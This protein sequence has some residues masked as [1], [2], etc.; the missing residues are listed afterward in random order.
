[1]VSKSTHIYIERGGEEEKD[2]Y[3]VILIFGNTGKDKIYQMIF[4]MWQN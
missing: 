1:M 2:G 3:V 4:K